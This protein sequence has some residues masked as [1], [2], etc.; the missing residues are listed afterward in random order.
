MPTDRAIASVFPSTHSLFENHSLLSSGPSAISSPTWVRPTFEW[1]D[2]TRE[3][4]EMLIDRFDSMGLVAGTS[5]AGSPDTITTQIDRI[6]TKSLTEYYRYCDGIYDSPEIPQ[7]TFETMCL[8][9]FP[10]LIFEDRGDWGDVRRVSDLT[11]WLRVNGRMKRLTRFSLAAWMDPP[12][13]L[14]GLR[15]L[16]TLPASQLAGSEHEDP[17]TGNTVNLFGTNTD[18]FYVHHSLVTR[19]NQT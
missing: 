5:R 19:P 14:T 13:S 1:S 9:A 3:K 11:A 15:R 6:L 18:L 17:K 2:T 10:S 4:A 16:D 12:V 8:I 7:E